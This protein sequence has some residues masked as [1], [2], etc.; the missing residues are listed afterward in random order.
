MASEPHEGIGRADA[1]ALAA[2]AA[3]G[4]RPA[5][6]ACARLQPARQAYVQEG[7]QRFRGSAAPHDVRVGGGFFNRGESR[8]AKAQAD[9][10]RRAEGVAR[11]HAIGGLL[12]LVARRA[13]E[14]HAVWSELEPQHVAFA[15]KL[16][17]IASP[18]I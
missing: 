10:R 5:W 14:P 1:R 16:V 9:A 8:L 18:P 12:R 17:P 7:Q 13:N 3:E 11:Q 4:L 15:L 2:A 6:R